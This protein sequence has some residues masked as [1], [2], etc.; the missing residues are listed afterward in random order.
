M[1]VSDA[2]TVARIVELEGEVATLGAANAALSTQMESL[3]AELAEAQ[4]GLVQ[5]PQIQAA[6]T[7]LNTELAAAT[8][9]LT[10]ARQ[11]VANIEPQLARLAELEKLLAPP[12]ADSGI[13]IVTYGDGRVKY[14][15]TDG[16]KYLT[17]AEA[18]HH[19]VVL[20]LMRTGM[21][22]TQ[23]ENTMRYQADIVKALTV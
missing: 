14:A 17:A 16:N 8:N 23:A 15:A 22:E 20:A 9:Q 18:S 12:S 10:A 6:N 19:M 21:S 7:R 5:M 2:K 4:A 13:V 3:R 1:P 11:D